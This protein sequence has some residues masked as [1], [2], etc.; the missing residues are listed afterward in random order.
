MK[1]KIGISQRQVFDPRR[2]ELFDTLDTRWNGL[3]K[4]LNALLVPIPNNTDI[5]GFLDINNFD[6][7]VLSGGNN[8]NYNQKKWKN[9]KEAMQTNDVSLSRDLIEAEVI[10]HS[11]NNKIPILGVCRG[12]QMLNVYFGGKISQIKG[13]HHVAVTHEIKIVDKRLT[14]FYGEHANVNSFHNYGIVPNE[15]SKELA[16]TSVCDDQIESFCHSKHNFHGI[17]WHPERPG[18]SSH[19]DIKYIRHIFYK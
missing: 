7:F 10:N 15:I 17:M 4:E 16:I 2:D 19:N 13:E 6:A 5:S 14:A 3:A 11:I 12:M 9:H 8:I 1:L 18:P